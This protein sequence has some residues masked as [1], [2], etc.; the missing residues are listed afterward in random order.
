MLQSV[1]WI[2]YMDALVC[3]IGLYRPLA[4][5]PPSF[6]AHHSFSNMYDTDIEQQLNLLYE[7]TKDVVLN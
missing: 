6:V 1:W 3:L 5:S 7:C 2:V 4:A